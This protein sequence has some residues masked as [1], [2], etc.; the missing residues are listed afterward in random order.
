MVRMAVRLVC[1]DGET[2]I[3]EQDAA[4]GPRCE[5]PAVVGWGRECGV[6]LLQGDVD[7]LERRG[8]G[9]RGADGEAEAVG[10]VEVVIGVL[11]EDDG[12]DGVEGRVARPGMAVRFQSAE[13][14]VPRAWRKRDRPGVDILER[15]EDRLAILLFFLQEPLQV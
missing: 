10:L 6:V 13:T 9:R 4:I 5:K 3:Q 7:I 12:L 2:G 11:A 15:R 8:R 1:P 14:L